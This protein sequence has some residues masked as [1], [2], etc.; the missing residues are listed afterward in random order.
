[1][2]GDHEEYPVEEYPTQEQAE[3]RAREMGGSGF[4]SHTDDDGTTIYMPFVTH[5]EYELVM[6]MK[7]DNDPNFKEELREK[8]KDRLN[9]LIEGTYSQNSL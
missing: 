1:V 5:E 3:A 9:Q 6:A 8:I 4:H 7:L 2:F